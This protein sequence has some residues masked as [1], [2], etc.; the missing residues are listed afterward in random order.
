MSSTPSV[1]F[2]CPSQYIPLY[3]QMP[4][5]PQ[6]SIPQICL[7]S[8]LTKGALKIFMPRFYPQR[9]WYNCWASGFSKIPM[10]RA[11]RGKG[12]QT[13]CWDYGILPE[14]GPSSAHAEILLKLEFGFLHRWMTEQDRAQLSIKFV[15]ISGD[16]LSPNPV[17]SPCI[18]LELSL[19]HPI[20]GFLVC[21]DSLDADRVELRE[22][23]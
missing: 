20:L 9:L 19:S 23:I 18:I 15:V 22:R 17:L 16:S 8:R 7:L 10:C 11:C 3:P 6:H 1:N 14:V 13:N 21:E 12:M 4:E 2:S 5:I